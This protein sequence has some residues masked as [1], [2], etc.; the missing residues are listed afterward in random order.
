[1]D[2]EISLACIAL[3][4]QALTDAQRLFMRCLAPK[5]HQP[6]FGMGNKLRVRSLSFLCGAL[7]LL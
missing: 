2:R 5:T 7:E 4:R 3:F 6:I 1:L